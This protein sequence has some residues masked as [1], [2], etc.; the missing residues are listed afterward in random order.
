[1]PKTIT[2]RNDRYAARIASAEKARIHT[3]L[4]AVSTNIRAHGI[5][6][7]G[8]KIVYDGD[9]GKSAELVPI[10]ELVAREEESDTGKEDNEDTNDLSGSSGSSGGGARTR[11]DRTARDAAKALVTLPVPGVIVKVGT[12]ECSSVMLN[13][14]GEVSFFSCCVDRYDTISLL[15]IKQA[16]GK[17]A[18]IAIV[19]HIWLAPKYLC[20]RILL[21][22]NL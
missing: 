1:M 18:L 9:G 15:T 17:F 10:A 22:W 5:S 19:S 6:E 20:S 4:L 21:R 3:D 8:E 14:P 12:N 7:V 11:R 13:T 16:L 2:V